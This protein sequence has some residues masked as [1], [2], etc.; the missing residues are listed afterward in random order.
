MGEGW[1]ERERVGDDADRGRGG[2]VGKWGKRA[3]GGGGKE[4]MPHRRGGGG[5]RRRE[6]FGI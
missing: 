4:G 6:N 3:G 1:G 2:G 5:G